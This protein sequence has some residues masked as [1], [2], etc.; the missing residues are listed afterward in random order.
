MHFWKLLISKQNNTPS[1]TSD[2]D[3]LDNNIQESELPDESEQD[4]SE[5][6]E[7]N[8][9]LD[10]SSTP[11][12]GEESSG[13]ESEDTEEELSQ[14]PSLEYSKPSEAQDSSIESEEIEESLDSNST[15]VEGEESLDSESEDTE[16][17]LSSTSSVEDS[18]PSESQ[19][20]STESD[21]I[22]ESPDTNTTP[23]DGEES[24]S[25]EVEDTDELSATPSTPSDELDDLSEGV[26]KLDSES[27]P[28][29][30]ESLDDGAS[31]EDIN[32][33]KTDDED[34]DDLD[35][36]LILRDE[37]ETTE[38]EEH[39]L[40][41]NNHFIKQLNDLPN[42]KDRER[43]FGYAIDTESYTQVPDSVI[44]TLIT[45]FLN[46]RFLKRDTDLNIRSNSFDRTSGFYRWGVKDVITHLET[47]QITKV[48]NDKY[49]YE[50]ANGKNEDVPLSFYFDLS[51]SMSSYTNMLSIV[52]IELLKK[53][54]KVLIGFNEQ[55]NV[56]IDSIDE[57]ISVADLAAILTS[58]GYSPWLNSGN[59]GLL[60]KE[61][62]VTLKFIDRPIDDYLKEKH[63]EKLVAF[64]DFDALGELSNLSNIVQVY[65]FCFE[66]DFDRLDV[67]D[68]KGFIYQVKNIKDIEEGL[69]K[70]NAKRFEALC[71]LD[72]PKSLRKEIKHD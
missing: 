31:D 61:K 26:E 50:Y 45:K 19:G 72:K 41:Q 3:K 53:G 46:Q 51:G 32:E 1:L 44:R 55:V 28:S 37:A 60:S 12:D 20:G 29:D 65:Y 21:G 23:K 71:Y 30:S 22:E 14:T 27:M 13:S 25:G 39:T 68:F 67:S 49:G 36:D 70:I 11:T 43:S 8:E 35:T 66:H 52:A 2:E 58:S 4:L 57:N 24:S 16:E 47:E 7:M 18:K 62:R 33:D 54:V 56:Q 40:D 15:P 9:S 63:A 42:F 64:S 59:K 10:S 38:D 17:E 48:L 6:K 34:I 69:V 5:S